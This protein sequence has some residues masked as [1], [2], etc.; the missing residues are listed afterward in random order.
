MLAQQRKGSLK[1][2]DDILN[3][4]FLFGCWGAKKHTAK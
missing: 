1:H 2:E 3:V 4:L